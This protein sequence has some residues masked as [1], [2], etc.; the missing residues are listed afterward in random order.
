MRPASPRSTA[1]PIQGRRRARDG[2]PETR[3]LHPRCAQATDLHFRIRKRLRSGW[4]AGKTPCPRSTRIFAAVQPLDA[5]FSRPSRIVCGRLNVT[6]SVQKPVQSR[7]ANRSPEPTFAVGIVSCFESQSLSR[8][9][10]GPCQA[11]ALSEEHFR[12]RRRE[13]RWHGRLEVS[14]SVRRILC[15]RT[16]NLFFHRTH[17]GCFAEQLLTPLRLYGVVRLCSFL[18]RSTR[19]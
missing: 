15:R 11:Q 19:I 9:W 2:V 16:P 4:H 7:F 10:S 8:A 17:L 6:R 18:S 14:E 5:V 12:A 1:T 3:R 13:T